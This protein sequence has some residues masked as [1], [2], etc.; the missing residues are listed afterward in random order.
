MSARVLPGHLK[1]RGTI[2]R[3]W[4]AEKHPVLLHPVHCDSNV[5]SQLA[6]NGQGTCSGCEVV[7]VD[8]ATKIITLSDQ[9]KNKVGGS[10][11]H[12]GRG[13]TSLTPFSKY[14]HP[15]RCQNVFSSPV[16]AAGTRIQSP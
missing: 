12:H 1:R 13:P 14:G 11:L 7:L 9:E 6:S 10:F 16:L 8:L 4:V 2:F 5:L 15:A 3:M